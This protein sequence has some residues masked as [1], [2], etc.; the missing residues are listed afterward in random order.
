MA[1]VR[2]QVEFDSTTGLP[3][4]RYVNTFHMNVATPDAADGA[5]IVGNLQRFYD[6]DTGGALSAIADYLSPVMAGT[7]VVK[8]YDLADPIPRVP[9]YTGAL[10]IAGNTGQAL[11][12]EVAV[13]LSYQGARVSGISQAS[14]RGRLYIGPLSTSAQAAGAPTRP[15]AGFRTVLGVAASRLVTD[16]TTDGHVWIV[17]S[18]TLASAADVT[19]GWVDNA[20]DTQRRR[21]AAATTRTLWT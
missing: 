7:A 19:D 13:V 14:R 2:V 5:L 6:L 3:E 1:N 11:P 20:F 10:T 16:A 18:P 12:E 21:G 4:D 9:F 17:W 8:C 15:S